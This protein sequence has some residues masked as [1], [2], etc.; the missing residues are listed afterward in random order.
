M[1][2]GPYEQTDELEIDCYENQRWNAISG[3]IST[4]GL[5]KSGFTTI[6]NFKKQ[7]FR[8]F[9]TLDLK[10]NSTLFIP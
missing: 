7:K 2:I 6:G 9:N 8:F 4:T 10:L 3:L 5:A 1:L